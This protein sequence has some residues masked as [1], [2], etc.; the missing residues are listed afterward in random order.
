M[1]PATLTAGVVWDFETFPEYLDAVR[2]RGTGLNFTS[3]IGHSALRLFA[4]GDAAYERAATPDEIEQMSRLVRE[5]LGAGA[6]GFSTSFSFAHRGVDGKPVP[7]RFAARDEVEALF[8]T[9]GKAEKGVVLVT[10]GKQCS[11][12]DF[13]ELQPRVGRPLMWPLFAAPGGAHLPQLK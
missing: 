10:P 5:A 6:A 2:R 3:Y 9:A 1:V 4:M 11:Y 7:S 8:L 13:Y 12:P